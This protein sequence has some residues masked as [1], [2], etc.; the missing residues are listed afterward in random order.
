M[1]SNFRQMTLMMLLTLAFG[2]GLSGL[3]S[4]QEVTGTIVGTVRD[5][6]GAVVPGASVTIT[7]PTK[8]N[9]VVR[10]L[11]ANDDGEFSAPNLQSGIYQVSVEAANF[12]KAVQTDVKLDVG[13]R[14][15]VEVQLEAGN[16]SETVTVEAG[17]VSVDLNTPTAATTINGDQVRELAINNRNFTQLVAL[18]PGVSSDLSDQVFTGTTNPEGQPNIV[19]LSVNGARSSQNTFTVDGADITDR[20]SNLTIQAYPSID[21]IGEFKVLRSMFPAESG[22]SGG[23]QVNVVTRSGTS[24]FRGSAFEF[25]RNEKFNANDFLTNSRP[26]L[27]AQLGRDPDTGRIN[28]RPFR[29]NNFG[30]TFGGPIFFLNFGEGGSTFKRYERTFFFFSEE[31]RRD[32]RSTTL[33]S[34][35][36]DANLRRGFFTVPVCL[37]ATGTTCNLIQPANTTL[38]NINP[39]SQQYL[40]QVYNKLPLPNVAGTFDLQFPTPAVA[41]FRQEI[42]KID[43]SFNDKFSVY[44]R[45]QN[46]KIPTI[47]ANAIFTSG[48]G[49]PNVST[50]SSNS[51]GR[52]HTA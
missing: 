18:A 6:S 24:E 1:K 39:V 30:F 51:P 50:T 26:Q 34:S 4:A 9:I 29:Y 43:H 17:A 41:D 23:G 52:T 48:S 40:T 13:Q 27:A 32:R 16:I 15:L 46:D 21:S 14:R 47:D 7:D 36:P 38:A 5:A 28:R 8:D 12:K 33:I 19:Q 20:G 25:V 31:V 11:T 42:I 22:R 10:N 35:L 3:A 37:Q 49:I 2:L 45:F 44:Y